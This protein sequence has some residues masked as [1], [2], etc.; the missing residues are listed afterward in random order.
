MED[1]LRDIRLAIRGLARTPG[2]ALVATVTLALGIGANTTIF[3]VVSSVLLRPPA[4]VQDPDSLIQVYTSDFSGPPFGTSS[5]PD[6]RDFRDQIPAFEGTLAFAPGTLSLAT[7]TGDSQLLLNEFVSGNYFEV[8]GVGSLL[9]RTFTA[10]EDLPEGG[11]AVCVISH[12]LWS[13]QFAKDPGILG[14]VL[15]LNG[16]SVTIVGVAPDGFKGSLPVVSVDL[17]IPPSTWALYQPGLFT[18]RGNRGLLVKGRLAPGATLEEAQTQLDVLAGQLHAEYASTWTDVHQEGRRIT[19]ITERE[20]RILPQ[21]RGPVLG[22]IG[23]LFGVVGLVLLMACANV[24]NL[25]LA[26]GTLKQ[27]E[28][29]VRLSLGASRS[30]LLRQLLTESLILAALGG[31]AGVALA[32][33]GLQALMTMSLP[34][35]VAL[36]LDL[37]MDYRVLSFALLLASSSFTFSGLAAAR[38]FFSL[39]SWARL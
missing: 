34:V 23:L 16:Q 21:I 38:F 32:Y 7:E 22:F 31:A 8:L 24:A 3:S 13:R 11:P 1:T 28:V 10:Q 20:G 25:L 36:T 9:G 27:R 18:S 15:R 17:W 29:G 5:Y 33:V 26:R 4:H 37:G 30:R 39:G 12:G 19:V 14:R 35:P 6:F 2:F